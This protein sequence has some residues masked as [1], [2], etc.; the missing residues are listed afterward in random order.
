MPRLWVDNAATDAAVG[1]FAAALLI[2]GLIHLILILGVDL[3]FP[4]ASSGTQAMRPLEI[5]VLQRTGALNERPGIADA[6]AP[7]DPVVSDGEGAPEA[8]DPTSLELA[9]EIPGLDL[10]PTLGETL[11]ASVSPPLP[12]PT[13]PEAT[14]TGQPVEPVF[15]ANPQPRLEPEPQ[16]ILRPRAL[17]PP[18]PETGLPQVKAAEILASRNLEV[19]ALTAR[20]RHGS[21]AAADRP[22][23]KAIGAGT[24]EYKYANYLEAWCRKVE[25]VGNLNYPEEAKRRKL[26][27]NLTLQV[28]L[29]ADGSLERVRVLRSSGFELLDEAAVKIV[30]LA[31][32]F[33]PFPPAIRA[34]TDM[35]DITRTWRFLSSNRLGWER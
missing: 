19:A 3:A 20:V 18:F 30:E 32:P 17:E 35:L 16:S 1:P 2:A 34:E 24:R 31:A 11:S 26:Y 6:S 12:R 5:M 33:S 13:G 7:P 10:L 22:R 25:R 29:R 15:S 23:R 4:K 14:V 21:T 28:A 9:P 8:D 27:G